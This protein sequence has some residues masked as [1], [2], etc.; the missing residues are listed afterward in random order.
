MERGAHKRDPETEGD[1]NGGTVS[2][3]SGI[4]GGHSGFRDG[5]Y[6]SNIYQ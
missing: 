3:E 5:G 2:P 4:Q 6:E 1:A